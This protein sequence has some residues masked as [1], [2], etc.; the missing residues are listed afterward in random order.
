MI[1][2]LCKGGKINEA[3][4]LLELMIQRGLNPDTFTYNALID[5]YCV[6]GRI[7]AARENF[8]ICIVRV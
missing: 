1:D 5:G 6:A 7:D 8:F 4:G 3:N 2:W